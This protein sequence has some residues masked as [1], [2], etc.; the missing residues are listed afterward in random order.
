MFDVLKETLPVLQITPRR[1]TD[2]TAKLTPELL[3]R[4][5]APGE[6]SALD[7][8]QHLVDA[9]RWVFPLRVKAFLA[10]E[11][12]PGFDPDA[13]GEISSRIKSGTEL[14]AEFAQ[15]RE[16]SMK[17]LETLQSSDLERRAVHGQL[18][19][20]TLGEMLAEWAAHDLMHTVQAERALMQPFIPLSG[21][22]DVYFKD[23][24]AK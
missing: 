7:C 18:G 6:W 22:W 3:S 2:L 12:F 24:I 13:Q 17:L 21:P 8:L 19:S 11:D 23:H 16:E 5:P 20:V 1:W 9:E 4:E 14:A 15:M 10:G